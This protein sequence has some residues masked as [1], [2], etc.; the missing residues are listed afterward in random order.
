MEEYGK[1]GFNSMVEYGGGREVIIYMFNFV[2]IFLYF[3]L[4]LKL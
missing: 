4:I 3:F 2:Y 1:W